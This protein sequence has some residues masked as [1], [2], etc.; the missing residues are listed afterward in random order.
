VLTGYC[1]LAAQDQLTRALKE[2]RLA[3][4]AHFEAVLALRDAKS[5]RLQVLK[6]D[7]DPVIAANPMAAQLFDLVLVPGEAPRLWID[8]ISFV[9]MEPDPHTYRLIQDSQGT[10]HTL[11]ETADRQAMADYLT[12]YLAHRIVA[13]DKLAAT[14]VATGGSGN[15]RR[16][17]AGHLIYAWSSGFLLGALILAIAAIL[18]KRV[19]F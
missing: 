5:L 2:A 16:Y 14:P 17:S 3:E 7:L 1:V 15:G 11:F 10:R 4:A 9:I 12:R 19:I 8:L 13:R 6:D 18:L